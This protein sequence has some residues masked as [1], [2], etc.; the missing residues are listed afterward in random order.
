MSNI[1]TYS[2]APSAPAATSVCTSQTR[3]TAGDLTIDGTLAVAEVATLGEQCHLSLTTTEDLSGLTF[4]IY[5]T[6]RRGIAIQ[7]TITGPNNTT[8][9]TVGNYNTVT[10]I[11]AS[12]GM[13]G[14]NLSVGN[15]SGTLET[16]W[17]TMNQYAFNKGISVQL[18]SGASLTYEVQ[19]SPQKMDL[20][21]WEDQISTLADA[22]LTGKMASAG[23]Q[24][25]ITWPLIRLKITN[26]VSGS[27][28][29]IISEPAQAS[30]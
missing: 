30:T 4:T 23:I 21:L 20:T 18:S 26:Y 7:E 5:G 11:A 3:A 28:V 9:N 10:R 24:T 19:Y 6:S 1:V 27:G 13:G 2:F 22:V 16:S 14:V 17:A 8:I 29:L 15:S 25:I 12:A